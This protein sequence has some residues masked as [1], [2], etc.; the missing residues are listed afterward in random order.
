MSRPTA[1]GEPGLALRQ[2]QGE[3]A[4]LTARAEPVEARAASGPRGHGFTLLEV[5]VALAILAGAM[6]AIS[7]MTGAALRNHDRAVRLEVAT[8]LARGKL[9]AVQD[10][11]DKD[12]FRDFDQAEEGTFE[13][14]GHPEVRW[15][16]LVLKPSLELGPDQLLVVLLGS[17]AGDAGLDLAQ[18]LGAKGQGAGDQ[19]AGL[20]AQ[21][22][23]AAAMLPLLRGQ[24]EKIGEQLKQ[25]L[26]ELR[27]TVSWKD[28][29]RD[30]AFTV[31]THVTSLGKGSA[32]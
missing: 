7:Q 8:L 23:G 18:L 25:G 26:R 28:G 29:A 11:L 16:L 21:L 3:R 6:L 20:Q 19:A 17:S 1:P 27:L 30:E 15:K 32:R 13:A 10:D 2:A 31:V 5:M 24:L 14:D 22:P 9:A 4:S 12:G